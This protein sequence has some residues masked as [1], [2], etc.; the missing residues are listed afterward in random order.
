MEW[1][2]MEPNGYQGMPV[3]SHPFTALLAYLLSVPYCFDGLQP[4][5]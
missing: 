3:V 4:V 5:P 1:S 2:G